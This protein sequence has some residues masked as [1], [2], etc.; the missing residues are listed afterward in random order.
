MTYEQVKNLKP[1]A[2]QTTVC[3]LQE[4]FSHLVEVSEKL[5]SQ[6]NKKR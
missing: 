3:V 6:Q 5:I 2:I 4:T 1:E